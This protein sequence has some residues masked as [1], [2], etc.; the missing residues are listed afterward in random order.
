MKIS[1]IKYQKEQKYQIPQII[2]MNIEE[3]N[4]PEQVDDKI[5]E[6]K[7]KQYTTILISDELASFS[8]N[9]INKYKNDNSINIIILP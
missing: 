6:L 3:I 5:N 8:Q 4:E 2:G 9:I 1:F 7:N